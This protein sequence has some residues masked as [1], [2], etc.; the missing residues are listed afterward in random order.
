MFEGFNGVVAALS[1]T[2]GQANVEC[3]QNVG[4]PIN[5]HLAAGF[6]LWKIQV[7]AGFQPEVEPALASARPD[8]AM[9]P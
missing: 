8:V 6:K 9:K 1:K 7:V 3:V 4:T 5:E 2:V